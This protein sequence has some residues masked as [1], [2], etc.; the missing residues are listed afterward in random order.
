ML[1]SIIITAALAGLLPACL[2]VAPPSETPVDV[3][4][5]E[6]PP[7]LELVTAC[8]PTGMELCF[9][10]LDNNCNGVID[11]GCGLNTGLLQFT[12]AWSQSEADVDLVVDAPKSSGDDE[13]GDVGLAR[14]R[15]CPNDGC[16]GQNVE[17]VYLTDGRP[18]RGAY[19]VVVRL[20]ELP[21]DDEPVKVRLS[22]R[23]GQRHYTTEIILDHSG[24]ERELSFKL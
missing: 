15:D 12:I 17:N 16:Y 23:I 1:R 14:D 11:E 20:A 7:D 13:G 19:R 10:A 21:D 8:V 2:E 18:R 6:A 4:K 22:A 9:D 24:D 5:V 3:K